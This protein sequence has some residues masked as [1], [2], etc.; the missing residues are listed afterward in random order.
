MRIARVAL[1]PHAIIG[2]F[3]VCESAFGSAFT[4]QKPETSPSVP[5]ARS[6]PRSYFV[7]DFVI[8]EELL[9]TRKLHCFTLN[10]D[11]VNPFNRIFEQFRPAR[12]LLAVPSGRSRG[13]IEGFQRLKGSDHFFARREIGCGCL[14]LDLNC[15]R[16]VW[17]IQGHRL[18]DVRLYA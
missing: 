5:P 17:I 6:Q 12:D 8:V 15:Q 9:V 7:R 18:M 10:D 16:I 13:E 11:E 4:Q 14:L 3:C 1:P 2:V